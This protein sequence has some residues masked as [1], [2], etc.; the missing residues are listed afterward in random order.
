MLEERLLS[1]RKVGPRYKRNYGKLV[2]NRDLVD[3]MILEG[4]TLVEIG[5]RIGVTKERI[6]QYVI[7]NGLHDL[8]EEAKEERKRLKSNLRQSLVDVVLKHT[9]DKAK[10]T[11]DEEAVLYY[12]GKKYTRQ[13][14]RHTLK[15]LINL[16]RLYKLAQEN[17]NGSSYR[18][19]AEISGIGK[20]DSGASVVHASV[21]HQTLRRM[22]F[23]S[24]KWSSRRTSQ[25]KIESFKR[26]SK[27]NYLSYSDI[28]YFLDINPGTLGPMAQRIGVKR[29]R[30]YR[31]NK[32]A[33]RFN[34]FRETEVLTYREASKIYGF[35]DEFDS[36]EE[37]IA[38]AIG[39]SQRLVSYALENRDEVEPKL[40]KALRVLYPKE[41]IDKPY[42]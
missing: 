14:S 41:K 4:K 33:V 11:G 27:I 26:A 22:G 19:L 20:G 6:R 39:K 37:E 28:A 15:G 5:N 30:G 32:E 3:D 40:I 35:R 23:K 31:K 42:R 24:L 12:L 18:K 16:V 13:R 38:D 21:V 17:D 25:E 8:W 10:E 1:P 9:L 7:Q 29:G 36:S 34:R 2:D